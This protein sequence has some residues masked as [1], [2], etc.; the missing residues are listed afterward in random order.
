MII[1]LAQFESQVSEDLEKDAGLFGRVAKGRGQDIV[2]RLLKDPKSVTATEAAYL[3]NLNA[4]R[5][6][7]RHLEAGEQKLTGILNEN[8]EKYLKGHS[9]AAVGGAGILAGG[10]ALAYHNRKKK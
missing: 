6:V 10:G 9:A 1:K 3:A 5:K 4:G 8:V 2:A 7:G